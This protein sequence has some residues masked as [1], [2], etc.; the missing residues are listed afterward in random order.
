MLLKVGKLKTQIITNNTELLKALQ[1]HYSAQYP[2]ASYSRAR[3]RGW[4]G[5]KYFISPKGVF[6][7]GLLEDVCLSLEKLGIK[8]DLEWF[9]AEPVTISREVVE[10]YVLRDYQQQSVDE[11]LNRKR[12]IVKSPTGS[13]K[14]LIM[15]QIINSFPDSMITVLFNSKHLL[16]QSY[17][18]FKSCGI[19][20]LGINFGEGFQH[21]RIML[22]T[23]QSIKNI[24]DPYVAQSRVLM[25]DEVHEFCMGKVTLAAIS[26]FPE[27]DF[28][29]GFTA[30]PPKEKYKLLNLKS[31]MG[32]I[33]EVVSVQ[34]L[35]EDGNLTKPIIKTIKF[36]YPEEELENSWYD[37]YNDVYEKYVV[38]DQQKEK[39][40]T[41]LITDNIKLGSSQKHLVLVKSLDHLKRTKEALKKAGLDVFTI[42]GQDHL[43][44]RYHSIEKFLKS[45]H[46]IL[47]GTKVLQTGIS[48]DEITHF[49]NIRELKSEIATIQALGRSLRKHETKPVVY[50]YDFGSTNVRYLEDHFKK[51]L[52]TYKKEGYEVIKHEH[53]IRTRE[54]GRST[55]RQ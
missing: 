24:I 22:S 38:Q 37:A 12:L 51:R 1:Y 33:H 45:K 43:S 25:V 55:D 42:E 16:T 35:I 26:S 41:E 34:E 3:G 4:D 17:E 52:T 27:A 2:G 50:V 47:I 23:V 7:T 28:R 54:E 14:T 19:E 49:Y 44:E 39:Y 53:P 15:A 30:T 31:A 46:G 18:F 20:D 36:K 48:I 10:N 29:F 13:G 6:S 21:G 5:K 8:Y 9:E 32:A 11:A 40:L